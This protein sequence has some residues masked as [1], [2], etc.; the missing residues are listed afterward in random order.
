MVKTR[1]DYEE[2]FRKATGNRANPKG[3]K[4]S[5]D[6]DWFTQ[7]LCEKLANAEEEMRRLRS[8]VPDQTPKTKSKVKE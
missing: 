1:E 2:E 4:A 5:H 8:L 7:W 6:P 3:T